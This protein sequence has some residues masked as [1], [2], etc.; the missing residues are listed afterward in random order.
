ME[1]AI[2][3]K[4]QEEV[5]A[6]TEKIKGA[7]TVVACDYAGL[8]VFEFTELRRALRA[9]GCDIKVYKNNITR[10]AAE[11]AGYVEFAPEM[12]GSK[13]IATSATDAVAQAKILYQFAEKNP[14]LVLHGGIVEG[15]VVGIDKINELATL[16]SYETLL[17]QLAAG[18]L[19]PLRE[20]AIGL[21]LMVE[22]KEEANA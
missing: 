22:P 4:K 10:R 6:L 19:A 21:N 9:A 7:K 17:T 18:M 2:I 13:A 3:L 16:P 5:N 14:K 20:L 11:S 1:K 15:E 8:T 12:K